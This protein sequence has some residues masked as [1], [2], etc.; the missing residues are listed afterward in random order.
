MCKC[1]LSLTVRIHLSIVIIVCILV[2]LL[3]YELEKREWEISCLLIYK[4]KQFLSYITSK[5]QKLNY[6]YY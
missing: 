6:Y 4:K 3:L 1:I 5:H 2:S